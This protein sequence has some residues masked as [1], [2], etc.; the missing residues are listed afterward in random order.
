MIFCVATTPTP[1]RAW[2]QRAAT[3][4]EEE[5]IAL[6]GHGDDMRAPVARMGEAENPAVLLQRVQEQHQRAFLDAGDA[7][8]LRLRQAVAAVELA[9]GAQRR[10]DQH[11]AH[12]QPRTLDRAG[13]RG[14]EQ[15]GKLPQQVAGALPVERL[16]LPLELVSR[17]TCLV[18]RPH[19]Y[20]PARLAGQV[21]I[22]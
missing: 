11:L 4:G 8:E 3:A 18:L 1:A 20:G 19:R 9:L 2:A 10:Q 17:Q 7:A 16:D 12:V 21:K 22:V 15:A 14:V 5:E 13:Q 6:L